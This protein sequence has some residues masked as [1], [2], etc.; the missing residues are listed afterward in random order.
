MANMSYCRFENT[1]S[2]LLDCYD[3]L[4]EDVVS[5]SEIR[6]REKLIRL[7]RKIAEK[8]SNKYPCEE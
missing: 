3:S 8:Y 4:D 5:K 2:D 6:A 1:L 7:C